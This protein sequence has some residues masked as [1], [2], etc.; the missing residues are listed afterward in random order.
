MILLDR[1]FSALRPPST[2][3]DPL[4]DRCCRASLYDAVARGRARA[5]G[6]SRCAIARR[7][8]A[9]RLVNGY[10]DG[11]QRRRP[12]VMRFLVFGLVIVLAIGGLTARLF[13]LQIVSG[14]E[15]AT[16][17]ARNRTASQAD[18]VVARPDLR[19][20]GQAARHERAD[21]RRQ[22]P[23]RRPAADAARRGRRR[24]AA[25]LRSSRPTSTAAIDGNPGSRFDLVRVARTSRRRPPA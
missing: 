19:P 15:F 13:Y 5:P 20:D 3:A 7:R 22:G 9:G 6:R 14:G 25:L 12:P 16:L 1:S 21:L 10:L 24:L 4:A 8:G 17:S 23:A 11:R 2:L 18:P